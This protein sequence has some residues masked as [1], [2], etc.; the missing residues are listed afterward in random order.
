MST[1]ETVDVCA[2]S[3]EDVMARGGLTGID[4]LKV[5]IEGAEAMLFD[6]AG[7]W[8]DAVGLIVIELHAPYSFERFR[9][10]VGRRGFTTLAEGSTAGNRLPM[11]VA[12]NRQAPQGRG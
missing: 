7:A 6:R 2:L 12:G 8:L 5:D 1:D 4:L 3:I 10:A 11:A 9:D